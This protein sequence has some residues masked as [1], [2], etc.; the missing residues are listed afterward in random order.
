MKYR[1]ESDLLGTVQVP[2]DALF[3]A[4]TQ[5][6]LDNFPLGNQ[7]AIGGFPTLIEA[8]L[9]VKKAA[10]ITNGRIGALDGE[11]AQAIVDAADQLLHRPRLDQFPIHSL[12]GGGGTSANMN[13]NEVLA[14][15][16]EELLGGRRGR[17]ELLHPNEHVN[18]HQSTNDV[19]PTAC[20]IAIVLQWPFLKRALQDLSA[21]FERQG[22]EFKTQRRIARTCLQ[23]AVDVSFHDFFQGYVGFLRRGM[24]RLGESVD[25]LYAVNLGG[26]I[27]GRRE[28]V[29]AQY[30]QQIVPALQSVTSDARYRQG[31]NLFDAAQN[32]DDMAAVSAQLELLARGLIKIAQ[33]LR[34][35]S[36]GPQAGWGE[37]ALPA[38]QPGSSIMPGKV[39]PVIPEF[40]IQV[41]FKVIG[42]H[43]ACVAGLDHGELDLNVWES[44]MLFAILDSMEL[45]ASGLSTLASKCV[46]GLSVDA[47]KNTRNANTIIP[48]LTSL[49]KRHGYSKITAVCKEAGGDFDRIESLLV[50]RKEQ[51]L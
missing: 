39:N 2:V 7:R 15:V 20:H 19:Y 35:L 51:A 14:N 29:P 46:R 3:G 4:Q 1:L 32:P 36:S 27:V 38:V 8:L 11:K 43:A 45:L 6:A 18:L 42:N 22:D 26:T 16:G 12:H 10:A 48:L 41:A 40:M 49:A 30:F 28:D 24:V 9:L 13:V 5:R 47:E 17:Y 50:E 44:S 25:R 21:E 37:L 33:D 31:Q 23:D 34:M